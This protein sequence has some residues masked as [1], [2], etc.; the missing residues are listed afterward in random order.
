MRYAKYILRGALLSAVLATGSCVPPLVNDGSVVEDGS[1][2]HPI[3][4]EPSYRSVKVSF[5]GPAAPLMADDA[6]HLDGLVEDYLARGNGSISVSAPEGPGS[7]QAIRYFGE[8]LAAMGVPR[9]RILVGTHD[10]SNGDMRVEIGYVGYVASTAPCGDWT[11][12]PS[13]DDANLPQPDFGCSVQQNMAAQ[14]SDPRD[15]LGPRGM[16]NVDA[17]RRYTVLGKYEQGQITQADKNKSDKVN[18]QS[19]SESDVG[20]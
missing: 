10:V 6:S 17:A 5:A 4:V 19:G 2:N 14:I 1:A 12:N 13:V 11:T 16:G 8:R 15:L 3:S 20:H 18:E 7:D 9:N